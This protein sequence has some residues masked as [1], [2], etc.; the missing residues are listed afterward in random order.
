MQREMTRAGAL[1]HLGMAAAFVIA[2]LVFGLAGWV[3]WSEQGFSGAT[4]LAAATV[5]GT[6]SL[7]LRSVRNARELAAAGAKRPRR[8]Q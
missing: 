3:S 6:I 2:G 5:L 4:V 1:A 8:H 7:T